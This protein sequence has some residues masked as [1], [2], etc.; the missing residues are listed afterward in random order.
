VLATW[1]IGKFKIVCSRISKNVY[2]EG[3]CIHCQFGV[4]VGGEFMSRQNM[5]AYIGN[6]GIALFILGLCVRWR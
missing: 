3:L 5:N 4:G 1:W 2:A 6:R